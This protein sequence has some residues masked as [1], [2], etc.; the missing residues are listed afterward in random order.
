MIPKTIILASASPRRQELLRQ[1]GIEPVI[2]KSQ[3]EEIVAF[4]VPEEVVVDL[5]MQKAEDVAA[6]SPLGSVVLG[7]DTVVAVDGMILGKP[8]SH[9]EAYEMITRIQGKT[10][11]V[12]TGVTI[13]VKE[14][15]GA[16]GTSFFEKT[17]VEVYPMTEEEIRAYTESKEPM[18]KAGAYAIQ[19]RFAA[20]IKGIRGDYSN[21]VGLP[22]GRVYQEIK[23]LWKTREEMGND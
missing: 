4:V 17:D 11:Q 15:D 2:R 21:V 23:N 18:D 8:K 19:G 13:M 16:Y 3:V 20:Y 10:H 1:M 5:S 7:A 22:L 6:D 12:Y 9:E 14:E